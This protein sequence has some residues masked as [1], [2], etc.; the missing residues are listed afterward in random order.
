MTSASNGRENVQ[1]LG[2]NQIAAF[3]TEGGL[4][5]KS[6]R[7]LSEVSELFLKFGN[8]FYRNIANF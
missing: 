7:N 2:A 6:I 1:E 3:S 5:P 4:F 8:F